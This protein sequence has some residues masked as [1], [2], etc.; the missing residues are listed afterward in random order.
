M[1]QFFSIFCF[2][3]G[4]Y[5][6]GR[7]MRIVTLLLMLAVLVAM[8]YPRF[9]GGGQPETPAAV[10]TEASEPEAPDR[11]ALGDAQGDAEALTAML[12][13]AMPMYAW[14]AEQADE[15]ALIGAVNAGTYAA[16][17]LLDGPLA[18]RYIVRDASMYDQREMMIAATLQEVYRTQ[19][20]ARL[21]VPVTEAAALLSAQVQGETVYTEENPMASFG[22]TY[23]IVML[24]Y[25]AIILYG[26]FVAGSVASEKSSR[27]MELLITSANPVH[28][29]FGKVLGAG[30]AGILQFGL[31]IGA[32]YGGYALN[33]SYW[34]EDSIMAA[35]LS[36]PASSLAFAVL[37]F[38]LGFFLYAFL[39]GALGSLVSRTEEVSTVTLPVTMISIAAFMIVSFSLN[40]GNLNSALMRISS[41]I[42]FTAPMAMFA[43][44]TMGAPSTVEVVLSIALLAITTVGMGFLA[45]AIY[46]VG[47]LLYGKPPKMRELLRAVRAAR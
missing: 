39:Y 9:A 37:F 27:A 2:E 7:A 43:R 45:A 4:V 13:A 40:L 31:L 25:M 32:V 46:R 6:R 29:M 15:T 30:V 33:A 38:L 26:Q 44:I 19:E 21:G 28:L 34:G 16:A 18:Y 3:L 1:K 12:Q 41:L 17:L 22:Y 24:L 8:S 42:P 20:M 47:V 23:A 5:V 10:E 35:I 36:I 14:T 11:I